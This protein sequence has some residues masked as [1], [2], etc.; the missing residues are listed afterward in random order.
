MRQIGPARADIGPEDIRSIAFVVH[1]AG[2]AGLRLAQ[3]GHI[4]EEIE[5]HATDGRQEDLEIRPRHEF[6]EHAAGLLEQA[7]P[8]DAFLDIEAPR[9][10]R[11]VPDRVH[12][13]LGHAHIA[14]GIE[15]LAIGHQTAGGNGRRQLR[16][17][18]M[19]ARDG[20]G[21]ADVHAGGD[22][23]CEDGGD[24][25]A[26]GVER[27]DLVRIAPLGMGPDGLGRRRVGQ[28]RTMRA[29]QAARGHRQRAID[30]IGPGVGADHIAARGVR[31]A[32][33]DRS[34]LGRRGGAPVDRLGRLVA[35]RVRGQDDVIGHDSLFP[36]CPGI[37]NPDQMVRFVS[38]Y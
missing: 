36:G 28:I 12:G 22:A 33:D 5:R 24:E 16:H 38:P 27:H 10:P 21:R 25:V 32:G 26:P 11:Q 18:D 23:V 19:G 7:A 35:A 13:S 9:Q 30:R 8:Q 37:R 3:L 17:I 15:D 4:A 1:A 20:N 29:L 34:T 2:H 6:R 31:E 14:I